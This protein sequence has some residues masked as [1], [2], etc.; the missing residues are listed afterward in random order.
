MCSSLLKLLDVGTHR[1]NVCRLCEEYIGLFLDNAQVRLVTLNRANPSEVCQDVSGFSVEYSGCVELG[2]I[3]AVDMPAGARV[4]VPFLIVVGSDLFN[5][6]SWTAV[7]GSRKYLCA[8]VGR[9]AEVSLICLMEETKSHDVVQKHAC[10]DATMRLVY[11]NGICSFITGR[12]VSKGEV[13]RP[14]T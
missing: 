5:H 12:R 6:Y 8:G 9:F 7:Q 10:T 14:D 1:R 13:S 4:L 2:L 11:S 3:A